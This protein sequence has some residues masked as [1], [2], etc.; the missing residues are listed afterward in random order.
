[1]LIQEIG[2]KIKARRKL[3]GITQEHLAELSGVNVNTIIRIENSRINPTIGVVERIG[4][5]LGLE[6]S[7][8][9]KQINQ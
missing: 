1:M 3:L 6:L 4:A 8:K 9:I 7:F 2:E 5:V